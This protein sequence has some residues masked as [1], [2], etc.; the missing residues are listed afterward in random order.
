MSILIPVILTPA[1]G[2]IDDTVTPV[3]DILRLLEPQELKSEIASGHATGSLGANCHFPCN[4]VLRFLV[5]ILVAKDLYFQK[6]LDDMLSNLRNSRWR[7]RWPP[8][9]INDYNIWKAFLRSC[10]ALLCLAHHI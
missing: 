6:L 8:L 4:I 3:D 9:P 10:F 1:I 5:L 7:P 2:N